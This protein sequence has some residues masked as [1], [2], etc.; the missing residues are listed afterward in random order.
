MSGSLHES[1]KQSC[2]LFPE[3]QTFCKIEMR[4]VLNREIIGQLGMP[5]MP[6]LPAPELQGEVD[7][8]L[9]WLLSAW[10]ENMPPPSIWLQAEWAG[11]SRVSRG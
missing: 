7:W 9:L 1:C 3:C 4:E 8:A 10:P 6:L 2:Q 5:C 11:L